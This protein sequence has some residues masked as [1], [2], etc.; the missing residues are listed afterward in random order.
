MLGIADQPEVGVVFR[1]H[2]DAL[3]TCKAFKSGARA[4]LAEIARNG[5]REFLYRHRGTPQPEARRDRREIGRHKG[6][7]LQ[8]LYRRRLPPQ[9]ET[10][11]E[12]DIQQKTP[13]D[14]VHQWRQVEAEQMLW[15]QDD[16]ACR[17]TSENALPDHADIGQGWE[18]KGIAPHQKTGGHASDGSGRCR[19]TPQESA[20]ESA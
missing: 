14:P 18:K 2:A 16:E 20:E 7:G 12:K 11:V 15:P 10:D 17:P 19:A 13:G 5:A 6:V 8:A 4:F 1:L 3:R 9:R